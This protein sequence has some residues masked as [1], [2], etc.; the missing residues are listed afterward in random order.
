MM[1]DMMAF[2]RRVL[3][4]MMRI[5]RAAHSPFHAPVQSALG[6]GGKDRKAG[7]YKYQDSPFHCK[8]AS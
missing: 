3:V 7:Q 8:T 6:E 5:D 4:V 1:V 2:Q